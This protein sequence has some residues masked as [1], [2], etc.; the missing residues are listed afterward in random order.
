MIKTIQRKKYL[1]ILQPGK[2]RA[3]NKVIDIKEYLE[4]RDRAKLEQ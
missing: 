1:R 3:I 4:S 2:V